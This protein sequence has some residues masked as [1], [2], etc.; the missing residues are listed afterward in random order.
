MKKIA[1][2]AGFI[3]AALITNTAHADA[4]YF[5]LGKNEALNVAIGTEYSSGKYGQ[6]TNTNVLIVPISVSYR[7]DKTTVSLVVPYLRISGPGNIV[8]ATA[9]QVQVNGAVT[10]P[11]AVSSGLGDV[12]LGLTQNMYANPNNGWAVDLTGN[13]K[14]GTANS[15][16]G[17]GTGETDYALQTDVAKYFDAVDLFGTLGWR[18]MG[19]P[20]GITFKNPGYTSIGA[21]Y[22]SSENLRFG[23]AYD[24][25]QRVI[26]G[27]SNF[28]E[29]LA[30]VNYQVS[31]SA[32]L[33]IYALK[34]LTDNSPD[35]G[36]GATVNF[37]Y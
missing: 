13:I 26:T 27:T 1:M 30:F 14:F 9:N 23:V 10:P 35:K 3:L 21:G 12:V 2:R 5:S 33:Q 7:E 19:N 17:L 6:T 8:G 16:S 31:K 11:R 4:D 15:V 18:K 28:A 24:F 20:P 25:R 22:S 37:A 29:V 36:L 34:G 32:R